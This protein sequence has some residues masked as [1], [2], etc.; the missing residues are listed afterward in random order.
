LGLIQVVRNISKYDPAKDEYD[1]VRLIEDLANPLHFTVGRGE[2]DYGLISALVNA[3]LDRDLN[4]YR[5]FVPEGEIRA[6]GLASPRFGHTFRIQSDGGAFQGVYFGAGPHL[7]IRTDFQ[8]DEQLREILSA[9]SD[10]YLPNRTF[11]ITDQTSGQAAIGLT[12][13]Y[14]ARFGLPAGGGTGSDRNGVYVAMNYHYLHG[15]RHDA[16]DVQARFDTDAQGLVTLAPATI[17]LVIGH[18]YSSSGRG[19]STDF[20][21]GVVVDDWQA[22]FGVNGVANRMDW[23]HA[24]KSDE[25]RRFRRTGS[26]AGLLDDTN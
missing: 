3:R 22:G 5:G 14:R 12:A 24:A 20:G 16:M 9:T 10:T 1:P 6:E 26:T 19:F 15:L 7:S 2:E 21:V 18:P 17:P 23:I 4:T 11:L 8:M 13:G 25:W